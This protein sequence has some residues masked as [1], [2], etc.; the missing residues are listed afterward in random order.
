LTPRKSAKEIFRLLKVIS[1]LLKVI[2]E[3]L[4]GMSAFFSGKIA[5]KWLGFPKIKRKSEL[6]F[7]I[8]LKI[9]DFR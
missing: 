8:E 9:K 1:E 3:F 2:S 7:C 6:K 4:K 5:E